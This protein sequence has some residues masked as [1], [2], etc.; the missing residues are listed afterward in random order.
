M[1][2]R[3]SKKNRNNRALLSESLESRNLLA[4][5]LVSMSPGADDTFVDPSTDIVLT[6][7][8][9]VSV[10]SGNIAIQANGTTIETIDVSDASKVTISGN[11]V[12]INPDANFPADSAVTVAIDAGAIGFQTVAIYTEGF[13][14]VELLPYESDSETPTEDGNDWSEEI[15][16]G[17][18]RDN[19]DTP[20]VSPV[21]F[22]GMV[23][24]NKDSWISTA[25]DQARSTFTKGTGNVVVADGDE[26]DDGDGVADNSIN[27]FLT[28]PPI[29][30]DGIAANT[31]TLEFDSSFRPEVD[32]T[33]LVDVSYD[34]GVTWTNL[35]SLDEDNV[36]GGR[37]S[38]DRANTRERLPLNNPA[39]AEALVRF[40]YV[41]SDN[42]WWWA[43][44]NVA[45]EIPG[46]GEF[47]PAIEWNFSTALDLSP[48]QNAADVAVDANLSVTFGQDVVLT[49]GLGNVD[50]HR[51]DGSLFESIPVSSSRVTANGAVVTIDPTNN[52]EPNTEYSVTIDD[53]SIWDTS[54]A[55]SSGITLFSEDF[56]D[57]TLADS[58]LVGGLDI[59]NYVVVFEGVLDVTEAGVYTFGGNSDDGQL[60]SI[61]LNQNG[62][63]L[64]SDEV[65]FDD[66][67]H[68]PE[69][70]LSTCLSFDESATSCVGEGDEGFD[71]AV[72]EYAFEFWYFENS[73][74]SGGELFYAKGTHEEFSADDFVL[75]GDDSQGIG[76]VGDG[77]TATTYASAVLDAS[78]DTITDLERA[79]LLIDGVI[80]QL[81]GFPA[82]ETLATADVWNTGGRGRF[83]DDNPVPGFEAPEPDPDWSPLPPE[84]WTR[85]TS[86]L[87]ENRP[88]GPPEYLGWNFLSREFWELEQGDQGRSEFTLGENIVAVVDPDAYDDFIGINSDSGDND[89][90][91]APLDPEDRT[92]GGDCGY[93]TGGLS[94]PAFNLAG[95]DANS[96]SLS[97]DSSWRDETTQ[98]AEIVVEFFDA[99]GD[100]IS[101][102]QLLRWESIAN[103]DNFKA[104]APGL[105]G[106][107]ET[108]TL[109]LENPA[110]AASA[111][112]TFTMPYAQNDWWWA[113]DNIRLTSPFSG[114]PIDGID[115]GQ[116]TF[117][118]G[119]ASGQTLVGDIDGDGAVAF[120]DFLI[121]SS[122]FGQ[123]VDPAGSGSDIDGNG[124]VGFSDFLLLSQ[125]FG[126]TLPAATSATAATTTDLALASL[127][128]DDE[129][130]DEVL[131]LD[132]FV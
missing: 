125:N 88:G 102:R 119:E 105:P 15:P 115:D 117:S 21:E 79:E 90:E 54:D 16:E 46:E 31:A 19:T 103:D 22:F 33:A 45:V 77:V 1:R 116:W 60:L 63:D 11:T 52:L 35:L 51:A 98:S 89:T 86:F 87:D 41:D 110:N 118:T 83:G 14:D 94:T 72:G 108:I 74:G 10:G 39:D 56:E 25:G 92:A 59:N 97:F 6:Y 129:D 122:E 84:G 4:A 7:D 121:L 29:S 27:V 124:N 81:E 123:D 50:I 67:T 93:F 55:N 30:L 107:N 64:I 13:E 17:W 66:S 113:I 112:V 9:D 82:T 18:E 24:H 20:D 65:I 2:K 28:T 99:A 53:F 132:L 42:N 43:F 111:V 3:V 120:A 73:G 130:E 62:L 57:L 114:N 104:G 131:S 47:S 68:G 78:I 127:E 12:T 109:P 80:Q 96:A 95:L 37:S 71:L 38:L 36:E 100:S 69:D 40:G 5:D 91:C 44:D 76:I 23:I 48:A 85:D 26:Y 75:V 49:P 8:E 128:S 106:I 61:D 58:G 126:A 32:Q 34:N 70:R 101:S